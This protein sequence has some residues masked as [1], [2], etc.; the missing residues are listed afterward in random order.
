MAEIHNWIEKPLERGHEQAWTESTVTCMSLLRKPLRRAKFL[1]F[2]WTRSWKIKD[3]FFLLEIICNVF[4]HLLQVGLTSPGKQSV[5][6]SDL[7]WS[8]SQMKA[9]MQKGYNQ[10][11]PDG[12]AYEQCGVLHQCASRNTVCRARYR[13]VFIA[14]DARVGFTSIKIPCL[15][16][17]KGITH[18]SPLILKGSLCTCPGCKHLQ[19][20]SL[21][22]LERNFT[23]MSSQK[24]PFY[25]TFK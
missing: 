7:F 5:L 6:E 23:L 19:H 1:P 15:Q 21:K 2:S 18:F 4:L 11:P 14:K 3:W 16:K 8:I 22:L 10:S 12:A 24:L 9:D 25:F 20:K 17:V 13:M